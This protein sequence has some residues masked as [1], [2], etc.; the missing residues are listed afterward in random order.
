MGPVKN[1][2][3]NVTQ[4]QRID[5]RLCRLFL[6]KKPSCAGPFIDKMLLANESML[7]NRT[8][9]LISSSPLIRSIFYGLPRISLTQS[10]KIHFLLSL[11]IIAAWPIKNVD[12]FGRWILLN[13]LYTPPCNDDFYGSR[14]WSQYLKAN[15]ATFLRFQGAM[16]LC[17]YTYL[18][19]P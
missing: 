9:Y 8:F 3:S 12:D 11:S 10:Q 18:Q 1:Q 19:Q 14:L 5:N 4:P 16:W 17:L 13:G 2:V 6:V 7:I 15:T